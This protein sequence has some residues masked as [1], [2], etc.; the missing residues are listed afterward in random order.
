[1]NI[2]LGEKWSTRL[3]EEPCSYFLPAVPGLHVQ[4]CNGDFSNTFSMVIDRAIQ[5]IH[6]GA[7]KISLGDA[8]AFPDGAIPLQQ[9]YVRFLDPSCSMLGN[10][11]TPLAASA[12]EKQRSTGEL[13]EKL[14][15]L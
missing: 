7:M 8:V 11:F 13:Q 15:L 9:H 2:S 6:V 1:M 10:M 3:K 5:A 4:T 14:E 12:A